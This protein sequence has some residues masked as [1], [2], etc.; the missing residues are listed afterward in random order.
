MAKLQKINGSYFISLPKK[1]VE[2]FGWKQGQEI[3]VV[4]TVAHEKK[5]LLEDHK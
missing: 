3:D 2:R 1:I 5:L 4:Q